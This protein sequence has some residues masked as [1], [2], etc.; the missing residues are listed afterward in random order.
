[1][2]DIKRYEVVDESG[3][4]VFWVDGDDGS[5]V[6]YD[7][8]AAIVAAL[9]E[10]VQKLTEERDSATLQFDYMQDQINF[11]SEKVQKLAAENVELK[12]GLE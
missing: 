8:H 10:Q 4:G 9:Q 3:D 12:N 1:M 7:D 5:F 2:T 6:L 11:H